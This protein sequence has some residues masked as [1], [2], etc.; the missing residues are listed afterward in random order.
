MKF[1]RMLYGYETSV[2]YLEKRH[3]YD[4]PGLLQEIG[5]RRLG[6]GAILIPESTLHTIR[7][8]F[9]KFNVWFS[10]FRVWKQQI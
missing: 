3:D 5:G 10:S 6:S 9:E 4:R 2:S 1:N 7:E 8:R